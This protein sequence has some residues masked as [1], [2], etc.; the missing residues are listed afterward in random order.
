MTTN[1]ADL[2]E[3]A[4][5]ARPGRVD[6]AVELPLPDEEGRRR[7][8]ELFGSGLD[9]RLKD[10]GA[11][12][13]ATEGVSPAFLRELVRKAALQAAVAGSESVEDAHFSAALA[14]LESGG[15]IT[16]AMLGADG[17]EATRRLGS[18]GFGAYEEW[19]GGVDIIEEP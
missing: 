18:H 5:A 2:L 8:I 6:Q 10:Q 11:V 17:G 12:V 19:G 1:R 9:L 16:R 4:L 15:Q 3:P 14:L 7:L 13:T